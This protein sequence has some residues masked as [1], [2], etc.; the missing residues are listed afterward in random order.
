MLYSVVLVSAV[1]H[2]KS[3]VSIHISHPRDFSKNDFKGKHSGVSWVSTPEKKK[4][5]KTKSESW[6][7]NP[8]NLKMSVEQAVCREVGWADRVY[9]SGTHRNVAQIKI[10]CHFQFICEDWY[11]MATFSLFRS[12]GNLGNFLVVQWLRLTALGP[13]FDLWWGN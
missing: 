11:P 9:L 3:V 6:F 10:I 7:S 13:G 12:Q 4:K 1:Q 2:H 8:P 5:E